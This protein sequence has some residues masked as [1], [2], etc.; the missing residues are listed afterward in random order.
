M[1][2]LPWFLLVSALVLAGAAG[3][4]ARLFISPGAVDHLPDPTR[5]VVDVRTDRAYEAG[6]LP[7]AVRVER[8]EFT[9][10]RDGL[11]GMT[12]PPEAFA[13]LMDRLGITRDTPV[14]VYADDDD[15]AAA[16]LAWTLLYYGHPAPVAVLDGGV[17]GWRAA[18]R[19]LCPRPDYPVP[20]RGYRPEPR[21]DLL[22]D[23]DFVRTS[24]GAADTVV[25]DVRTRAEYD[26]TDVRAARAGHVPGAV[27]LDWRDLQREENGVRVLRPADD[28]RRRLAT[29]GLTPGRTVIVMCQ[30]GTRASY[31]TL[32]LRGLGFPDVRL[33]D[34]SWLDWASRSELP[35]EGP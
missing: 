27:H 5:V 13:F 16:R 14:L 10:Q 3:A 24:M 15:P 23:A 31:A 1:R 22:A 29:L 30:S 28:L 17:Q 6:H 35:V 7:G 4:S 8:V 2:R 20:T 12:A 33:Y 25:W 32:A 11:D 9:A 26:G 18:G 21:P 19:R 34:G